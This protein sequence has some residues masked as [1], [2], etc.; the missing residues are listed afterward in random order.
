MSRLVFVDMEEVL[1]TSLSAWVTPKFVASAVAGVVVVGGTI[2]VVAA[3]DSVEATVVGVVD[4]D[5][6]DV[7]YD[8]AEH[9]VRLLNLDTPESVDPDQ[10]VQCLGPEATR[11]LEDLLPVGT[12]VRLEYDLERKDGYGRELAGV[13]LGDLF[14]NAEVAEEG[15]GV[16]IAVGGNLRFFDDVQ[17]GQ[18]E[19]QAAG[20]GLYAE[21]VACTLPAR[22]AATQAAATAA[23][24]L[25]SSAPPADIAAAGEAIAESLIEITELVG[26]LNGDSRVFP[27]LPFTSGQLADLRGRLLS[28]QGALGSVRDANATALEQARLRVEAETRAA[29]EAARAAEEAA[30]A[31]AEE[32]A[33]RAAEEA[34]RRQA[35]QAAADAAA[36][37]SE[38]SSS[39][40]GGSSRSSGSSNAPRT[41]APPPPPSSNDSGSGGPS[42][43]TGCRSYAPGGGSWTPIPC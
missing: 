22:V 37:A 39:S 41:T 17:A 19:A 11:Y 25:T 34:A 35:E 6:I 15:L 1:S 33:R 32:A 2:A 30:R 14:V 4:G 3:D 42:G 38:Q 40:G 24:P 28:A 23:Q 31:A 7:R 21:D 16:A 10:P 20:R 12:S 26:E 29:E 5:T 9:R 43:Y 27:L 8:G 13:F 18:A 36:A